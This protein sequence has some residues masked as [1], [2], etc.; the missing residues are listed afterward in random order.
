MPFYLDQ[1]FY[2]PCYCPILKIDFT[3]LNM[4]CQNT[5]LIEVFVVLFFQSTRITRKRGAFE[6]P[7]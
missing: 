2:L 5:D 6:H 3:E 7:F 4:K 1:N